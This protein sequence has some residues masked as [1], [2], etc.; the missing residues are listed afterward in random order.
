M[1]CAMRLSVSS[2]VSSIMTSS[3]SKLRVV[4]SAV[5][6]LVLTSVLVRVCCC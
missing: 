2:V 5:H 6:V 1:C 4:G 3:K